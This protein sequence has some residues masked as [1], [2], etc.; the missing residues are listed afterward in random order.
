MLQIS[1]ENRKSIP[2]NLSYVVELITG[3]SGKIYQCA[4]IFIKLF[5]SSSFIIVKILST[6]LIIDKAKEKRGGNMSF[7]I[8]QGLAWMDHNRWPTTGPNQTR[9]FILVHLFRNTPQFNLE[10]IDSKMES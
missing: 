4:N 6:Q 8:N 9:D 2:P 5:V 1:R 7:S 3:C 10:V